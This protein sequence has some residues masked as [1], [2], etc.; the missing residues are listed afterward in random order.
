MGR[1]GAALVAVCVGF[2]V[3]EM[4][5]AQGAERVRMSPVSKA[6]LEDGKA[7]LEDRAF[8]IAVL[9]FERAITADPRN[10]RAFAWLGHAHGQ[11]GRPDMARKYFRLALDIDPGEIKALLWNGQMDVASQDLK[12]ARAKL[13]RMARV[14]AGE[15]EEYRTL[16]HSIRMLTAR[17]EQQ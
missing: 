6:H 3:L 13:A 2:V 16:E 1:S 10:A 12:A 4:G 7:A 11:A 15:C 14:C 17:L 5:L 9:Q 8:D